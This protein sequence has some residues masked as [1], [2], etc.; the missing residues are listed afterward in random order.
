MMSQWPNN[1]VELRSEPGRGR[2]AEPGGPPYH[3]FDTMTAAREYGRQ[4]EGIWRCFAGAAVLLSLRA[5]SGGADE[6]RRCWSRVCYGCTARRCSWAACDWTVKAAADARPSAAAMP[7]AVYW[8][9]GSPERA[10]QPRMPMAA[11][12]SRPDKITASGNGSIACGMARRDCPRCR[13][14]TG[15]LSRRCDP[16]HPALAI[17]RQHRA[18]PICSGGAEAL[19]EAD[20]AYSCSGA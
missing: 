6:V 7:Q 10:G 12:H 17:Y 20:R 15:P 4:I 16:R 2:R 19:S 9:R 5:Q 8:S 11:R 18:G 13:R 14:S 1:R 3:A